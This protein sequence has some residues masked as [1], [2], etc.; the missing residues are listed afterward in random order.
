MKIYIVVANCRNFS[1][2]ELDT[3]LKVF[4]TQEEAEKQLKDWYQEDLD[5]AGTGL[6]EAEK[7]ENGYYV[8]YSD[9]ANGECEINADIYV[10]EV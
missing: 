10:E 5:T 9:I 6:L 3:T 4:K 1:T 7:W 2:T 8:T